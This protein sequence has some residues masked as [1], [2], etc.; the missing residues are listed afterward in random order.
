MKCLIFLILLT[1][2]AS[3]KPPV[4]LPPGKVTADIAMCALRES[5][6][7]IDVGAWSESYCSAIH[8][9]AELKN[10]NPIAAAEL[11]FAVINAQLIAEQAD[12]LKA[13]EKRHRLRK[14]LP[15]WSK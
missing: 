15:K 3:V 5:Y 13:S 11:E 14:N 4:L 6:R 2:C 7:S 9:I 8:W 10:G 1:G 12:E